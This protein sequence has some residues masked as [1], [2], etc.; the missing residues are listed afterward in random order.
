MRHWRQGLAGFA[1]LAAAG[2]F[3]APEV[4]AFASQQDFGADRVWST[5]PIPEA[6]M[7]AILADANA[8]TQSSPLARGDEARR[9]FLTDGGWRWRVLALQ[10]HFAFA[11]TRAHREDLIFNRSDI[12]SDTVHN[13]LGD[14]RTRSIAGVIAHE[15]CHGMER[16][17]FGFWVDLT[18]PTWVIEGY[19]DYVAQESTLSDAEVIAMKQSDPNHPA[20]PCYEGRMKVT[21]ILRANGGDVDAL[22]AEA[23]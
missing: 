14:G 15:K 8:R 22:F 18:K 16:R 9:I 4:L 17:H 13:G 11:L 1:A 19:C 12:A 3:M 5:A 7:A 23:N 10:S 20:L 6:R 21:A 2:P